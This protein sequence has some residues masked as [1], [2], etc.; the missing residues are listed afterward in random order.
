MLLGSRP[1]YIGFLIL[2]FQ[3]RLRLPNSYGRRLGRNSP[4]YDPKPKYSLARYSGS[5][6]ESW[7]ASL[8]HALAKDGQAAT[9]KIPK[10][11]AEW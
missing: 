10:R 8:H 9:Q 7:Y 3:A 2:S 6:V 4:H 11:P 1:Y 5:K